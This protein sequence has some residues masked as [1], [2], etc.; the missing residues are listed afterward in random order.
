[1][2]RRNARPESAG[3]GPVRERDFV[4]LTGRAPSAEA[5][6][7]AALFIPPPPPIRS[8]LLPRLEP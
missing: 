8:A 3:G 7:A 6:R 1:M 5:V 4:R 2:P